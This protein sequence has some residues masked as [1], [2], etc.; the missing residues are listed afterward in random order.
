MSS[1]F[2][3][4]GS[5]RFVICP[6]EISLICFSLGSSPIDRLISLNGYDDGVNFSLS[7]LKPGS[8]TITIKRWWGF[9]FWNRRPLSPVHVV[10]FLL[11]VFSLAL[12]SLFLKHL[13]FLNFYCYVNEAREEGKGDWRVDP[14]RLLIEHAEGPTTKFN[15]ISFLVGFSSRVA[16]C[17]LAMLRQQ[18]D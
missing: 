9:A 11:L 12:P 2:T 4:Y 10:A 15:F 1:N 16:L 18:Y 7:R 5:N 17:A 8:T 14:K 13:F 3:H 6:R